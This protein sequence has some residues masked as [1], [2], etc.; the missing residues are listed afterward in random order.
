MEKRSASG[1][2]ARARD[3][4]EA[5]R[6]AVTRIAADGKGDNASATASIFKEVWL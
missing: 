2:A 6:V 3:M 4:V 5:N 1:E